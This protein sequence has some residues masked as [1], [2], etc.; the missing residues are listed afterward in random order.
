MFQDE[1]AE[2]RK[3]G[4]LDKVWKIS[5]TLGITG[6]KRVVRMVSGTIQVKQIDV[7]VQ[8][9]FTVVLTDSK[10]LTRTVE[11]SIT[12]KQNRCKGGR[13]C[14]WQERRTVRTTVGSAQMV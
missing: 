13:L 11:A 12:L 14:I 9:C 6:R 1:Q 10:T 7:K 3:Y 4:R 8:A 5:N 2:L